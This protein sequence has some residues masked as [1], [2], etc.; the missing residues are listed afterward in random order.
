[1]R[2]PSQTLPLFVG[3][4]SESTS[5]AEDSPARIFPWLG[6]VLDWL[7]SEAA[8]GGNSPAS[9]QSRPP[10][11]FLLKTSAAFCRATEPGILEP[12]SGRWRN[13]GMGSPTAFL[14][15]SGGEFPSDAAVSS[16][17]DVLVATGDVPRKYCLSRKACR[18]IL[19]RA[20]KRGRALPQSLKLAL[21]Q[22][23]DQTRCNET[24][25]E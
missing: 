4:D 17:S 20:E 1:M 12:Y 22:V 8:C 21:E 2:K 3:L 18:G 23:A 25:S 7:E 19:R 11:G 14:T 10:A 16:L 24:E 13:S 6:S 15:L 5:S 9:S